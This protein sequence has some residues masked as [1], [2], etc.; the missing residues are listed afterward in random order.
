MLIEN[1][2]A[3]GRSDWFEKRRDLFVREIFDSFFQINRTF[4]E[5]Y[6]MYL[7]CR[8]GHSNSC[9]DLFNTQTGASLN[10]I[11]CRL[12][13][14]VGTETEKGPLW[15]LKDLCHQV[16]PEKS[17]SQGL[18][19]SFVDWLI[20]SV[21]H[22]G[23]KLKENIYLLNSYGPAAFK[24]GEMPT[25]GIGRG[26]GTKQNVMHFSHIVDVKGLMSRIGADVVSQMELVAGLLSQV[27][28]LL[29]VMVSGL[30]EN[31]LVVRLL[32]EREDVIADLWGETLG[33]IYGEMF[34][35]DAAEGFCSAGRS[36]LRGQWYM[37]ALGMYR[38]A[39]LVDI[40]CDEAIVKTIQLQAI[41]DENSEIL[42]VA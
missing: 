8:R 33:T 2:M 19:G 36:Y 27:N 4:R 5:M 21:F 26:F 1:K 29:R 39:L 6:M 10:E 12:T 32:A 16:W 11:W 7:E 22:E 3:T 17:K 28:F 30:G 25:A 15:Q 42:G 31:L 41:V 20:G 18:D 38:R 34:F 40:R 35:G 9:A 23:M 14:F 13:V 24:I 37:Q